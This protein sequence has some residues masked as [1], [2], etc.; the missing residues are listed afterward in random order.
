MP[1]TV[2]LKSSYSAET[3]TLTITFVSGLV[4]NY[5]DVPEETYRAMI[6]SGSKGIYFNNHIKGKYAFEKV[7]VQ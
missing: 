4:Y 2:I 6:T 5:K 7:G 1:S 3:K